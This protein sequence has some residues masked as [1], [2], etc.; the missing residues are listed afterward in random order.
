MFSFAKKLVD[1]LEGNVP[2]EQPIQNDAYFK[3]ALEINNKGYGLRVLK[4]NPHS[5]AHSKGFESWFDYIIKINNHELPMTY[6][7]LST[8]T[9]SISDDGTLNY[10]SGATS[11]QAGSINFELLLQEIS[12][13]VQHDQELIV[14]VWSAKGG[15]VRQI[16]LPLQPPPTATPTTT[17]T[18]SVQQLFENKFKQ[19]GL[20]LQ[21]AHLNS[22]TFVWRILTTHQGSPAF[23]AQLVP[24]SDYI[25]GCDSAYPDD[26]Y[27]KGLI[28]GGGEALLSKTVSSYYNYHYSISKEDNIPITFYVYN[29][30]YDILRPV[31]VNLC[32]SWGSGHGKGL[33][34][35]DVGYG[36]LHRIPEVIGKFENNT[37]TENPIFESNKEFTYDLNQKPDS[38][39]S[40]FV[41]PSVP[42]SEVAANNTV[43]PKP[44]NVP[45]ITTTLP[46]LASTPRSPTRLATARKKKHAL[47][48]DLGG[49]S[50]YMNEELQKSK[51]KDDEFKTHSSESVTAPPPP[52]HSSTVSK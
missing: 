12:T 38:Q 43:S 16:V 40:V 3:D 4:V 46:P 8:Y 19:F 52:P 29:H 39:P 30:E 2:Q 18:G 21:S 23:M 33:L 45:P 36:Y 32:R 27:G 48:A 37:I 49:L 28:I 47:S 35:C 34:G 6:P 14:D 1:R 11:E 44:P 15:V 25:I 42:L 50:D 41:P 9:Y 26:E 24:R 5:I 7:S 22:A 17:E 31:T 20:T 13:L 10:G 51:I